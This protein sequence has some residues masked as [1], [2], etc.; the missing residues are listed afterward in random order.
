MINLK[1]HC[2]NV[3]LE[4][5]QLPE[6]VRDCDCPI[7]NRLGALWG[8]FELEEVNVAFSRP[9]SKYLWGDREYEMHHCTTCGCTTHYTGA[10]EL[11]KSQLGINMRLLDRGILQNIPID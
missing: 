10:T 1:C 3:S 5:E 7:C 6:T 4:I 11:T 9:T 8:D 2:E